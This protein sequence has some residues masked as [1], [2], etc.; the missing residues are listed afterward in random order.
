ME[1]TLSEES[2]AADE[3]FGAFTRGSLWRDAILPTILIR[4]VI[5]LASFLAAL[6]F[7]PDVLNG[8]DPLAI[9]RRWDVPHYLEVARDGYVDPNRSVVFPLF[10][11]L[12]ALGSLILP[13]LLAGMVI[14]FVATVAAAAGLYELVRID[15][16]RST[17][18]AAVLAMNVFPTAYWLSAAYTDAVFLAFVIWALLSARQ[19]SWERA[20]V[21]ALLASATRLQGA[22]LA[23]ALI[24][25]YVVLYRRFSPQMIWLALGVGGLV[26]YLGI[27]FVA[28]GSPLFFVQIQK[29]TFYL[30][31]V[32]PWTVI[33]GLVN[34][35]ISHV[36]DERWVTTYIAPLLAYAVLGV[37][38]VWTAF[39]R[40]LRPAY[41]RPA[42]VVYTGLSL[43]TLLTLSWPI[44]MP[45]YL[46]GVAPLFICL[47]ILSR[48]PGI[49]PAWLVLSVLLLGN[50][51][52]LLVIGHW[53]Y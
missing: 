37:V 29:A 35:V 26:A 53:A 22:Y 15:F 41:L 2:V 30:E 14:S 20:G 3:R 46:M 11:G 31:N 49:G 5:V 33:Q 6:L 8:Q 40:P 9:W 38:A 32:P 19:G 1:R 43:V 28:Y 23:P 24:V 51:M 17:A 12:I 34:G 44:S 47:G 48:R 13:S 4:L 36:R 16:D 25:Q 42:Y 39:S 45:R 27:N 7:R 21:F 52:T 10:P 18:R 50:F